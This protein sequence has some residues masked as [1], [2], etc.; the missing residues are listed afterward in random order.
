MLAFQAPSLALLATEPL[1]AILEFCS[2]KVASLSTVEGDGHPVIVYPGLG[3]GAL[4]TAQLRNH[5]ASCN[6]QVHDWDRGVNTGPDGVLDA[7]LPCLVERVAELHAQHGRKVSLV[8]WSLGGIYAREIAKSCPD[9]V[10]QVI[11]LATP[12]RSIGGAN[13]AGTIFKWM[14]GDTSQLT[15][16][17]QERLAQ[18]PP[19][20]TTSIY[21]K[22]DGIVS[23]RGCLEDPAEDVENIAVDASHLGMPTH[24]DVLRIVA[25]RLAQPESTW[26]PYRRRRTA[27][28]SPTT[29]PGR[30]RK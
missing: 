28:T 16:E 11:T 6:F 1:R 20:P 15:V 26:R 29:A 3:A 10:R 22:T 12:H 13:H 8:G 19:V 17:L 4:T 27:L 23:W 24:P 18:R 2:A 5:L 7:W 25:H 9:S 30:T 14:G 21:S